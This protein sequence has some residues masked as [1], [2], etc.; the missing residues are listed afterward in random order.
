VIAVIMPNAQ[1]I[2]IG[3]PWRN[4]RVNVKQIEALTGYNFFT[5]VRPQIRQILKKKIDTL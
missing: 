3:T 1:N 4:F 2:G 5:N